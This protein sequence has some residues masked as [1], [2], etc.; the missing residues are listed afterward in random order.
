MERENLATLTP[1]EAVKIIRASG[2]KMGTETL[3]A[4]V[5]Q[6]T[7]PIGITIMQ[8]KRIFLIS[9]KKLIEWIADFCG[10]KVIIGDGVFDVDGGGE[11]SYECR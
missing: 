1:E 5:E 8:G 4:G 3:R 11:I 2:I 6:E 10:V 7:L 9:K